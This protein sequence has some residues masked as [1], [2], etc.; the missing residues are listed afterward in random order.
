MVVIREV[1]FNPADKDTE[2]IV[3]VSSSG[4]KDF[5]R[6]YNIRHLESLD[7]SF[8]SYQLSAVVEAESEVIHHNNVREEIVAWRMLSKRSSP[9]WANIDD[10]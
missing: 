2:E 6:G 10:V 8:W 7:N 9:D 3:A 4:R 5:T 1:A